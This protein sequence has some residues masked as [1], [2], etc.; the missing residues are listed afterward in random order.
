MWSKSLDK[1]EETNI[2][3]ITQDL[4]DE[5]SPQIKKICDG[6]V[7]AT[8][9]NKTLD[10][11]YTEDTFTQREVLIFDYLKKEFNMQLK[12]Q[13][14]KF[15]ET[16]LNATVGIN[17]IKDGKYSDD[18]HDMSIVDFLNASRILNDWRILR[19]SIDS[20]PTVREQWKNLVLMLRLKDVN[21]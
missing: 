18:Y 19:E 15:K 11:L 6:F 10:S 2:R 16:V 13:E 14:E 4:K 21:R 9:E 8:L 17:Q 20:H 7:S 12:L 5:L 1:I 3:G